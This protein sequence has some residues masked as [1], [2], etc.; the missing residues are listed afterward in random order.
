[1]FDDL[2]RKQWESENQTG[3]GDSPVHFKNGG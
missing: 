2:T 1:M 3:P